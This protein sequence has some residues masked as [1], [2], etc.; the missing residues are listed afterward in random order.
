MFGATFSNSL[1]EVRGWDLRTGQILW[2]KDL[3][4]GDDISA[5]SGVVVAGRLYV[6]IRNPQGPQVTDSDQPGLTKPAMQLWLTAYDV[7]TGTTLGTTQI[8]VVPPPGP[9]TDPT[10]LFVFRTNATGIITAVG[11]GLLAIRE[12]SGNL[13][14]TRRSDTEVITGAA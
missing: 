7:R 2:T 5:L 1:A 14:P 11:T 4:P 8:P 6:V 10:G 13:D 3:A 9:I 12:P